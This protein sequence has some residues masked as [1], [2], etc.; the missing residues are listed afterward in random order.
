MWHQILV[1]LYLRKRDPNAPRNTNIM[2]MHGMNRIS[3]I[4]FVIALVVM[5]VRLIRN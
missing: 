4:M 1:Y 2:L 5:I 3:I